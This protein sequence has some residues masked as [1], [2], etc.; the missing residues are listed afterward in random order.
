METNDPRE[1]GGEI[2]WDNQKYYLEA[3]WVGKPRK[4]AREKFGLKEEYL[5]I[6]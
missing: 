4:E 1:T 3:D 6:E 2:M 5:Y